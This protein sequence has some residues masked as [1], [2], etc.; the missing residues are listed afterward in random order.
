MTID[1]LFQKCLTRDKFI[2]INST[3]AP[4]NFDDMQVSGDYALK[5]LELIKQCLSNFKK[6]KRNIDGVQN[7]KKS[8]QTMRE[9]NEIV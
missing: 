6:L 2:K 3:E 9:N 5:Q 1:N 4:K 8:K 7:I